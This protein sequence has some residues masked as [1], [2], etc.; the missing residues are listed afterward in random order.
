[1]F[2]LVWHLLVCFSGTSHPLESRFEYE[3]NY[4]LF[5][6]HRKGIPS[7]WHHDNFHPICLLSYAVTSQPL[8]GRIEVRA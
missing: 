2:L 7:F 3:R 6:L 5:R 8:G 4:I 1:M